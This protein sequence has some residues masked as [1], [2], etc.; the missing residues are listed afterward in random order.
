MLFYRPGVA[1]DQFCRCLRKSS[2]SVEIR[3]LNPCCPR[4]LDK[5]TRITRP[6]SALAARISGTNRQDAKSAKVG[7][8]V[9]AILAS[10]RFNLFPVLSLTL[11]SPPF[12]AGFLNTSPEMPTGLSTRSQ[13]LLAGLAVGADWA[14][15]G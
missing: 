8:G 10:S 3:R 2:N 1:L 11:R 9:F 7:Q 5:L 15:R 6:I 12:S 13:S 14:R 4:R